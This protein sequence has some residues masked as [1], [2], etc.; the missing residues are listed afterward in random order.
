MNHN[1]KGT[2]HLEHREFTQLY[3]LV[4]L[5][6][7]DV[8]ILPG[9]SYRLKLDGSILVLLHIKVAI[10]IL[11]TLKQREGECGELVRYQ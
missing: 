1:L 3:G 9:K 5:F 11:S 2:Y 6:L 7:R 10:D 8:D 4:T